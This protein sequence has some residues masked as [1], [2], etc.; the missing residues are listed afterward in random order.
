[1][2]SGLAWDPTGGELYAISSLGTGAASTLVRVSPETAQA[3]VIAD[4]PPQILLGLAC[5]ADGT[6][7]G[8]D[9]GVG[10]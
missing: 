10:K 6:L 7:Y 3:T 9:G 4:T 8:L 2:H 1:T 5:D